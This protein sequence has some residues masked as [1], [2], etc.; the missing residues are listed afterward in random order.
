MNIAVRK[1]AMLEKCFLEQ[2][3]HARIEGYSSCPIDRG[4]QEQVTKLM[5]KVRYVL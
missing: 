4:F 3:E 2:E 1:L 5:D